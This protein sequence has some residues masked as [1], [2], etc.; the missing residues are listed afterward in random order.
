MIAD[1][2]AAAGGWLVDGVLG[3][4]P[5]RWHPVAWFGTAMG[6]LER[7][8]YRDT[9][10]A[11]AGHLAIGAGGAVLGGLALRRSVGG[12]GATLVASTV[13]IAG[14]MLT[15]EVRAVVALAA[16]DLPAAKERLRGLVG[17]EA[18]ALD[19]DGV[20]RAAIE[21]LAENTV[22][23]V[24][25]PLVWATLGGAPAVLVHRAINTL[26]AM[27]GHRND[28]YRNFGWAAARA[29]DVAN[30]LPARLTALAVVAVRPRR[31]RAV[32]TVV[33]RDARRHPSPNGGVIEGAFAAALGV[34]LGGTNVYG[35]VVEDRGH[36]GD[37]PPPTVAD[38]ERA[39]SLARRTAAVVALACAVLPV[40][41]R[42][43]R[44]RSPAG[45]GLSRRGRRGRRCGAGASGR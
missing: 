25:A 10:R 28:R 12:P 8:T 45:P 27:V 18:T 2:V 26:D 30:W 43:M 34:R 39:V 14:R 3:E 40:A 37:G 7:R 44:P 21:S 24:T 38:G 33:R 32:A 42:R 17:R 36:L 22:D 15:G 4:P 6:A 13:C 35:G 16:Q 41:V 5:V 1:G 9:R 23:A 20:V 11:G 29:D 19:A 31:A